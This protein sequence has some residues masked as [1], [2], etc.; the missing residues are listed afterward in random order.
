MKQ[1]QA[2]LDKE[3]IRENIWGTGALST[4]TILRCC[5]LYHPDAIDNHGR[6]VGT[7]DDFADYAMV[8]WKQSSTAPA[9]PWART[10][11]HLTGTS[12]T[13]TSPM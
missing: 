2:L 5:A 3:A 13:S 12:R 6:F 10:S 1:L 8:G 9:I 11:I 7:V 4:G